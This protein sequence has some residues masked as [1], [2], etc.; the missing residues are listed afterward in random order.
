MISFW[1]NVKDELEY[2]NLT[3]KELAKA[4]SE[5]Y[6]TL[7]TWIKN[8]RCPDARQAVNI[9]KI[10]RTSVEFL[11]TG[12]DEKI[13]ADNDKTIELLEKAIRTLKHQP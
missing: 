7:Q 1:Q 4:I 9:A 6:N 8:D 2:Q 3:Q 10:L 5:S 12:K 11:V 13:T